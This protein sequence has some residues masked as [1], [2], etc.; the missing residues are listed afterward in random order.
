MQYIL[1]FLIIEYKI[2]GI[3][4]KH[5][6]YFGFN[7]FLVSDHI[8]KFIKYEKQIN[9]RNIEILDNKLQDKLQDIF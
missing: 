4:F 8:L 7:P 2:R 1:K 9:N 5:E 6:V 3:A